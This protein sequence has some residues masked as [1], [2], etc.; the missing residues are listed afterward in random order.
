MILEYKEY[1]FNFNLIW[2]NTN[3]INIVLTF[4][5]S[6]YMSGVWICINTYTNI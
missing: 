3:N 1:N 4:I 6:T 2:M 5:I